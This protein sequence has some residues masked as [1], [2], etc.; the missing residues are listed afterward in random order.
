MLSRDRLEKIE[1]SKYNKMSMVNHFGP[2]VV[3]K[4]VL[5]KWMMVAV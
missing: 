5:K 3:S 4:Y 1:I 2:Q